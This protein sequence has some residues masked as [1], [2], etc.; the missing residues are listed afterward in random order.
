ME[1][2]EKEKKEG[3]KMTSFV[4]KEELKKLQCTCMIWKLYCRSP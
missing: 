3:K 2:K 1:K 4:K